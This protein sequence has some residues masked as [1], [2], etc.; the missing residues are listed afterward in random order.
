MKP[1][2][3]RETMEYPTQFACWYS[4]KQLASCKEHSSTFEPAFILVDNEYKHYSE[5]ITT[6]RKSNWEDAVL[7][8]FFDS[9]LEFSR[10]FKQGH[11]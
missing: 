8:A 5:L 6:L 2:N 9:D 11:V 4:E 1:Y 3:F 10:A 7:V